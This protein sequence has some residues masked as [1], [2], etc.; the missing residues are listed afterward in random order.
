MDAHDAMQPAPR[1][2][3]L[4]YED[5]LLFPDDGRRH[6]II[7]GEHYVT[8]SPNTRHQELVG[9]LYFELA[10]YLRDHRQ[11]GRVFLAPFDVVFTRWDVV[12]PDLL[13]VAGDQTSI[14]TDKNVQ[15]APALVVEI[16]SPGT[17]KTDEQVKRRL[18]D[19]GGV[20]EYWLVDPELELIKVFRRQ[21]DGSFRRDAELTREV[22]DVLTTP[23]LEGFTLHLHKL[24]AFE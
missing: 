21:V 6:E 2:T 12:E 16:L 11:A 23:L 5:F 17:R 7:D 18:F 13:L 4:T 1:D 14:I 10:L 15:G 24:F 22:L 8:P 19:R 9:R 3:R 20:R